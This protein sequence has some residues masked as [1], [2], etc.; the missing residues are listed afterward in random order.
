MSSRNRTKFF[1]V[2]NKISYKD[3]MTI[4]KALEKIKMFGT[5]YA[6]AEI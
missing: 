5:T 6:S 3:N 1:I 4:D 2:F